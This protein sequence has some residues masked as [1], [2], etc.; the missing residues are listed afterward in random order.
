MSHSDMGKMR[1]LAI[2]NAYAFSLLALPLV[3]HHWSLLIA[4]CG[5][6]LLMIVGT[7]F[8]TDN[9]RLLA[10]IGFASWL[11]MAGG[12]GLSIGDGLLYLVAFPFVAI[13]ILN[14]LALNWAWGPPPV[15]TPGERFE[16]RQ[17]FAGVFASFTIMFWVLGAFL[18]GVL[19]FAQGDVPSGLPW[20]ILGST[21][22]PGA[23]FALMALSMMKVWRLRHVHWLWQ[24]S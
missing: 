11:I 10:M 24:R 13:P 12:I 15:F 21:V 1:Q 14:V 5:F 19:M 6:P 22:V 17:H 20:I 2:A 8:D 7:L 16:R 3:T 9:S 23:V 18:A 4:D